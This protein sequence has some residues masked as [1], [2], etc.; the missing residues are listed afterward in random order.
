MTETQKKAFLTWMKIENCEIL[1]DEIVI[2]HEPMT[3]FIAACREYGG[4]ENG[5]DMAS[6]I[7]INQAKML[8]ES[9]YLTEEDVAVVKNVKTQIIR[10]S[11]RQKNETR[12]DLYIAQFDGFC[13]VYN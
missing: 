3:N 6:A 9:E 8:E 5:D 4:V 2:T 10:D 12:C 11:Q 7:L 1:E 13:A